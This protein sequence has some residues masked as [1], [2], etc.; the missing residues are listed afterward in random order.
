MIVETV[1]AYN[2]KQKAKYHRDC[3]NWVPQ[4]GGFPQAAFY[5]FV[6]IKTGLDLLFGYVAS[7]ERSAFFA[8]TKKEAIAKYTKYN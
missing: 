4:S 1:K 2:V 3:Q 7:N 5:C 8:R 6:S